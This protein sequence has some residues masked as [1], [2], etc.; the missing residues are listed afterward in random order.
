MNTR[1]TIF[2][3]GV[4]GFSEDG[5]FSKLQENGIDLFIDIRARRGMRGSRYKFVNSGYLQAKLDKMGIAYAHLKELAPSPE[6]RAA[7]GQADKQENINK[8]QRQALSKPFIRA[9]KRDILK[10]YKRKP[11]NKFKAKEEILDRA[12]Q[13]AQYPP[14]RPL[15]H[16]A[17]F[18]VEQHPQA[19]HRSLVA[20][21]LKK[22]LEGDIEHIRP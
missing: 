12:R 9:Y 3:I 19:C 6:M 11:E 10:A 17:L 16:L 22:Q 13:L 5:F 18:C 7:Q 8:R 4:Y 2:T 1:L 14:D 21:E 15:R 20:E